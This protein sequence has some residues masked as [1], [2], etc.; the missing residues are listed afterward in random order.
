MCFGRSTKICICIYDA[1][2]EQNIRKILNLYTQDL[3]YFFFFFFFSEE[4]KRGEY[5]IKDC[6]GKIIST[7]AL[8]TSEQSND[9][10][11]SSDS[12]CDPFLS[13][14]MKIKEK[15]L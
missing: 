11:R 1:K 6:R 5:S 14:L 15:K 3:T 10:Y 7:D 13:M 4:K 12:K 9:K 8:V 2:A